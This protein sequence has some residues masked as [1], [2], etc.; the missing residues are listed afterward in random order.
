MR[1]PHGNTTRSFQDAGAK[2]LRANF[3]VIER[4]EWW[5]WV[6]AAIITLLLSV[7]LV[8]FLLPNVSH[9]EDFQALYVLPQAVRGLVALV[10]IFDLYTIYQ[11]LQIHRI[12][13][14]LLEREELFHL[15]SENAADM[16]AVVDLEGRRI[17]NSRSYQ[18]ILGYSPEE[19]HASSGF[20]QIHP[21]DRER[22]KKAANE[23]LQT[24]AGSTLEY[25]FRHK[26]GTWMVLESVASVIRNEKGEPEKLLIVNRDI[27]ERKKAQ[28]ALSRSEASFRSLVEGAPH[29]I[30][31]ATM[32]GQ[33]L[34]VNPA[35]QRMLGY[36][37]TEELFEADL[38]KQVF[39][40]SAD[41][42]RM[43]QLLDKS[44][45]MRDIELEWKRS[46]GEPIVVRCSGHRVDGKDGG[47][48]YFEVYAE[49]IT[50]RRTLERQLRMAQK[51][52]AIGRLS[53]G[54]AHD[55]NN[56]LGVIIG[57]S[58]VLK[59][60]LD[61][62][63]PTYEFAME[64]EKA[65]QRAASMTRQLLAFS[66]QQVLTPSVLSLNSLV[67]EMEKMLPRLLG[68]DIHVSLL[69]ETELG[70]VKADQ[71]QIEQV[72]MN[73][74]VNARDAMPAGGKLHI[75][76][77]NFEMDNAFTRDH[78]G[79]KA[80]SYVMLAI[81]DSG[82]GMAPETLAHI[83]EPFFTT[84]GVGEG[85]GLGLATVYGI[86]KQSN[87]YIWV[88]SAPDQGSTFQVYLPKHL[89]TEQVSVAKPEIPSREKLHGSELILLVEDADALRKL[90]QAFLESNGFRVLSAASGEAALD[91]VAHHSGAFDLLLTD[92]VMPGMNGRV[93]AEQ[94]S[95]RQPGL[96]VL[97]MSGY[98]DSFIA[99]HG[100]LQ[101]GTNLLHKPFTEE[102]LIGKV[103]DVL[104]GSKNVLPDLKPVL[105]QVES[106]ARDRR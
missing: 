69:L 66:R 100:V 85:T 22:V 6:A 92:V 14:Q 28:E 55:F 52:E 72:I 95:M 102:I 106:G 59:K 64:I 83:F 53:G 38:V 19:L 89:D 73:L 23:T 1:N 93:L 31:R 37:S 40:N 88:E 46:N 44:K 27:T 21:E 63:Q 79:S 86:V 29:G 81:T 32:S 47:P 5:L 51:M 35:L 77:A 103:R 2:A 42:E 105:E 26:N 58:G 11:H 71:S 60:S 80:G 74:A 12:R 9:H 33:F 45:V 43:N 7:A 24:E 50:E 68:E 8:S 99:G 4:R 13:R 75:R 82:T 62:S 57:Y 76:T 39:R 67:S 10:F 48:D 104:D 17:F 78:P 97:F 41:Y 61:K 70:N 3:R 30:Y 18:R 54:I 96:K 87:G 56:L 101:Q 15:I 65:G 49:D 90:V 16:I 25:R 20:E 34:E 36:E 84:K 98:T 91:I 94:L